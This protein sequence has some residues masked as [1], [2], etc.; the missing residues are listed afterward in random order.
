MSYLEQL[1]I[2]RS[3]RYFALTLSAFGLAGLCCGYLWLG[4]ERQQ[5]HHLQQHH[6]H[7]R[8]QL[9]TMQQ[10]VS[11][12]PAFVEPTVAFVAPLFSVVETLRQS[13]GQLLHWQPD[14]RQA[15]LEL[16][17]AWERVPALFTHIAHYRGLTLNA[18]QIKAAS[19]A[20]AIVLVLEFSYETL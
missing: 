13:R 14:A 19:E 6:V 17:I 7:L 5:Y 15:R 20:M 9:A 3:H 10:T 16:S 4:E 11:R 12:I 8:Q 1:F 2:T 18:F